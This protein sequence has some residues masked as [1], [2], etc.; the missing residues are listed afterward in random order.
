MQLQTDG[1]RTTLQCGYTLYFGGI[2]HFGSLLTACRMKW[3]NPCPQ[4]CICVQMLLKLTDLHLTEHSFIKLLGGCHSVGL[5][6]G[7]GIGSCPVTVRR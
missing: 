6:D 1:V 7:I 5:T 4:A 3:Q 2:S